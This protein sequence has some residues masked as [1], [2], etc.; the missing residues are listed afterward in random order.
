[1]NELATMVEVFKVFAQ[2]QIEGCS[3]FVFSADL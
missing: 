1:M 3:D 2:Q